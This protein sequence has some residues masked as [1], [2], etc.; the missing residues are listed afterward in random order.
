[1]THKYS[2]LISY[3]DQHNLDEILRELLSQKFE[4]IQYVRM[5]SPDQLTPLVRALKRLKN[6]N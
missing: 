5:Q 4:D 1:M 2:V 3:Q 6:E